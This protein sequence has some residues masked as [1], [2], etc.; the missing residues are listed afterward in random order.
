MSDVTRQGWVDYVR[1]T[2]VWKEQGCVSWLTQNGTSS[3]GR[4]DIFEAEI[5]LGPVALPIDA[6]N[7]ASFTHLQQCKSMPNT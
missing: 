6:G 2:V 4:H 1:L 5:E 3:A 7:I